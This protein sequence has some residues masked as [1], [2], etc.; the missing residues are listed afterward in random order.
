MQ[1][2]RASEKRSRRQERHTEDCLL[3][4]CMFKTAE[5]KIVFCDGAELP[6]RAKWFTE[7]GCLSLI[8]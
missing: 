4:M 3:V 5:S 6:V 7:M 2:L 8:L 1:R